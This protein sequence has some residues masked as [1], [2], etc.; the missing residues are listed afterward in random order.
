MTLTDAGPLIAIL[1]R[2]DTHHQ[3][4]VNALNSVRLPLVTTWPALTEAMFILN[5]WPAQKA[6]W[7]LLDREQLTVFDLD[8]TLI[9]RTAELMEKY[10]DMHMDLADATLVAVAEHLNQRL[11]FTVDRSDFST[12][13]INNRKTFEIVP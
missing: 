3:A 9:D 2:R 11:I 4:C 12:Y 5:E 8:A 13:R 1:N 10:H 7:K 6:L